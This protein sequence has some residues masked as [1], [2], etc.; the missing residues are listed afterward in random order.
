MVYKCFGLKIDSELELSCETSDGIDDVDVYIRFKKIECEIDGEYKKRHNYIV[1]NNSVYLTV[2]GVAIYKISNGNLVEIEAFKPI[3]YKKILTFFYGPCMSMLM[4]QRGLIPLHGSAVQYKNKC[5][6]ILGKSKAGKSTLAAALGK[7]G[8]K[9]ISDDIIIL[10]RMDDTYIVSP[11]FANQKLWKDA[12]EVL[13]I[14]VT[15]SDRIIDGRDKYYIRNSESFCKESVAVDFAVS[16]EVAEKEGITCKSCEIHEAFNDYI[17]Y[18]FWKGLVN[19]LF[20]VEKLFQYSSEL[21]TVVPM[22]KIT[23]QSNCN[24][25]NE[26][27]DFIESMIDKENES[28]QI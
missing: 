17:R 9:I 2:K 24:L 4:I 13:D 20:G 5:I 8:G 11:G 22:S 25:V 15:D 6:L 23:R 28:V 19:E 10:K 26:Q 21:V 18:S 12:L 1:Y 14:T 16:L 7:R 27:V 3:D